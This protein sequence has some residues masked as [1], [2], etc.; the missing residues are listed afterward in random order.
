[1]TNYERELF[2]IINENDNP[3]R[4]ALIAMQVFIAFLE[5]PEASPVQ[6]LCDLPVSS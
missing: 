2:N 3:E 4:A 1:M 6:P 5:Q